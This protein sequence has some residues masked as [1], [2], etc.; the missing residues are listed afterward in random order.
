MTVE[1]MLSENLGNSQL[2]HGRCGDH[3]IVAAQAPDRVFSKDDRVHFQVKPESVHI[4]D[5][6]SEKA[7][8]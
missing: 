1:I 5:P 3:P 6:I 8:R 7:I 4:F 2:V